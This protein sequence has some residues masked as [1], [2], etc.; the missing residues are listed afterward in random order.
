MSGTFRATELR[1]WAARGYK[2]PP[3]RGYCQALTLTAYCIRGGVVPAASAPA[4]R[5]E[6]RKRCHCSGLEDG[7]EPRD[8]LLLNLATR[9]SDSLAQALSCSRVFAEDPAG[10]S[11]ARREWKALDHLLE[12]GS[13]PRSSRGAG[14]CGR[15]RAR[16]RG[17]A[18]SRK[19]ATAASLSAF[20]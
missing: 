11:P 20:V 10:L 5:P 2:H 16:A 19:M 9:G 15:R 14:R 12:A 3:L 8:G 4:S 17:A 18:P 6:L 7:L 13:R 1:S